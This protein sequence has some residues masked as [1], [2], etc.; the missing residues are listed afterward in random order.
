MILKSIVGLRL[1]SL[2]KSYYIAIAG[3]SWVGVC[4][5]WRLQGIS[6]SSG[7]LSACK[8]PTRPKGMSLLG[9]WEVISYCQL[10]SAFTDGWSIWLDHQLFSF[11]EQRIQIWHYVPKLSW[12]EEDLKDKEGASLIHE[13]QVAVTIYSPLNF[14]CAL[15]KTKVKWKDRRGCSTCRLGDSGDGSS[16]WTI[17]MLS[18]IK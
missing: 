14:S 6:S 3:S 7:S 2:E 18:D 8:I 17:I 16:P 4:P 15:K 13:N 1:H 9:K 10:G 5:Y 11:W 12:L